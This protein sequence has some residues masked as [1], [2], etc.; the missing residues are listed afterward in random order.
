MSRA[1]IA[2]FALLVATSTL[3]AGD[4]TPKHVSAIDEAVR[5]QMEK[6][7][8]VGVAVGVVYDGQVAYL[9]GYGYADRER[10]LPATT[11][12]VFNWASN[13]KPVAAVLA[14]QLVERG[15]L[16]LDA[17]V[18]KL[19]PE[20]PD[21]GK[22]I[23]VRHLLCHQSGLPHYINGKVV[24]TKRDYVGDWPLLDP[25]LALDRF[26][27]SPLLFDPGA[28]TAYTTHGYILLC[29]AIQ[30]AAK[31]PFAE[32]LRERIADPLGMTSLQYDLPANG[33]RHWAVGYRKTGEEIEPVVD[34]AHYWK[35]GGGG[36]KSNIEDFARWAEALVNHRLM[37]DAT[38]KAMWTPQP[39]ADGKPGTFALGF[40]VSEAGGRFAVSHGGAQDETKTRMT[41]YP[42][43]RRAYVVMCNCGYADPTAIARAV[44][45]A[46]NKK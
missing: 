14:M 2:F 23:T 8:L 19:V 24:P 37:N 10:K 9:K 27:G 34:V 43:E 29:A 13:S 26:S 38:Q 25:V 12:T 40:Q 36:F 28:K 3:V 33:Q 11:R 21:K 41:L 5:V 31:T 6:Q 22:A 15:K 30:R 46:V 42:C 1:P 35:H 39:T 32:L 18:R 4:L 44:E 17:D 45:D 7:R 16:D 20:F